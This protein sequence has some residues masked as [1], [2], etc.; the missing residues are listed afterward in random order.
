M[1][2]LN[3]GIVCTH[4]DPYVQCHV[5]SEVVSRLLGG[6]ISLMKHVTLHHGILAHIFLYMRC[7]YHVTTRIVFLLLGETNEV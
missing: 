6:V 7:Q 2:S 4:T 3:H 1:S 5:T